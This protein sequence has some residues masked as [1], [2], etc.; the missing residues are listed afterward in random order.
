MILSE[1]PRNEIGLLLNKV[2]IIWQVNAFRIGSIT[3]QKR[4][5]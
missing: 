1:N 5:M 3:S 4:T 2:Q